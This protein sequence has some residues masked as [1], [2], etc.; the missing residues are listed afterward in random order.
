M[1]TTSFF[2]VF[3]ITFFLVGYFIAVNIEIDQ[4]LFLTISTF[5]F[6]VFNGF[7]ITRQ[8]QRYTAI[9]DKLTTF[10]GNMSFFY[11]ISGYFGSAVQEKAAVILKNHYRPILENKAWDWPL[12]QKTTTLTD[13][14]KLIGTLAEGDQKLPPVQNSALGQMMGSIKESQSARKNLIALKEE[15]L[16]KPQWILVYLLTCML[17]IALLL[18]PSAGSAFLSIAKAV[19]ASTG[20]FVIIILQKMD[21]LSFFEG[22]VGEHSAQDVLNIIEGTK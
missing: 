12:T 14:T 22:E 15:V 7:F 2:V 11:R 6:T 18:I 16:P 9:R 10:D 8:G 19:F 20:L 4:R 3:F 13:L 21:D 17:L 1:R 5:F